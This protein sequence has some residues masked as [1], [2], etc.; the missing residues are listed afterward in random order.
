[1]RLDVYFT[2][3]PLRGDPPDRAVVIDVLRATSTVV[4]ALANG[5]REVLP[6]ATV[7]DATR[8]ARDIGRDSALLCGERGGRPIDGFDLGNAPTEVLPERVDGAT[9]VMTTSNGTRALLAVAG[10]WGGDGTAVLVGS[11][12]NL[13]AVARTLAE[14]DGS[15]AIVC[16][17]RDG[18]FGLDDA[19]CAGALIRALEALGVDPTL[20]DAGR[21]ARGIVDNGAAMASFLTGTEA[22]RHLVALGRAGDVEL[23]AHVDRR[24]VVPRLQDSKITAE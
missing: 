11:L 24:D 10:R 5:A 13:S 12:L 1:M 20:N 2:P 15:V 4:E 6:V 9:L 19:G 17:G 14:P 8:I 21:A 16:A 18:R 7:D 22:G 3:S 23:C